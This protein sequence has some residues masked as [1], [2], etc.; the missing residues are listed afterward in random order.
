[1]ATVMLQLG[2]RS[3]PVTARN[4]EEARVEQLGRMLSERWDTANRAAG[5]HAERAL[6]LLSLMLAD[7]LDEAENRPPAG[8]PV[9]ETALARIADRL[10]SLAD[11]LENG[12]LEN[13]SPNA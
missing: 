12:A 2:G 9:S 5:G 13:S 11:A 3:W 4:G 6:L 7:A 10:E 1:M 8:A